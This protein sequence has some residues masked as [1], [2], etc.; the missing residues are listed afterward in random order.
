M[1]M[2]IEARKEFRA[3]FP[4]QGRQAYYAKGSLPPYQTKSLNFA[5]ILR[6]LRA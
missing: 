5:G 4:A 6:K 3:P 2:K 1:G